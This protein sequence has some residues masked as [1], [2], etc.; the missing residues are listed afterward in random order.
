MSFTS[1]AFALL[2][3]S[4]LGC[5]LTFGRDKRA[6]SYLAFILGVSVVFYAW[7]IPPYL[8][9]LILS[10]LLDY[11]VALALPRQRPGSS[12][13]KLILCLSILGNMGVLGFFKY[14][15]FALGSIDRLLQ[16]AGLSS[17][18][19]PRLDLILPMGISFYTFQ[20]MSYTIDVYRGKLDPIR[21]FWRFFLYVSFFPQLVAGPIVRARD[22]LYQIDRR[23]KIRAG[24]MLE[25][26][27]LVIR[28]FFLKMVVADNV[29]IAVDETW[30][31]AC[32]PDAS[33]LLS[34][35]V[36]CLFSCQI[37]AD[38]AGYS[39]IARGAAYT[40]GFRVPVNF[41]C[42]YIASTFKEFWTRW[43]ISLSTWLRD[44]LYF[45]LGGNRKSRLRTYV[46]LMI[47]MLLGGLWHGAATTFV[48]WG[49][50]HGA[51]LVVERMLGLERLHQ[52]PGRGLI[53]FAWALVVQCTVLATWAFFRAQWTG[54]GMTLIRR[55]LSFDFAPLNDSMPLVALIFVVPIVAMHA[56][57]WLA[58][59]SHLPP[60]GACEKAVWAGLMLA[61]ILTTYG[62]DN[63][64]IYFQF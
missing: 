6:R 22:F 27:F 41:N 8:C 26:S 18:D 5:R 7:H 12:R 64:F 39:S 40:M 17:V 24:V 4:V 63:A 15:N 21:S 46:N 48:I 35:I 31:A 59:R 19:L 51:A 20:S 44:Y 10:C 62:K 34:M 55:I 9:I 3:L 49:A 37:F 43:H 45:S 23:R 11:V 58:D 38:F 29:A 14:A 2:F 1:F 36:L 61:G 32:S 56:R 33:S 30:V 28:G 25:G 16:V 52:R 47:V 60:P 13:A 50:M 53:K 42:P 54:E 57:A